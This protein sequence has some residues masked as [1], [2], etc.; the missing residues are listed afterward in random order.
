MLILPP[1]YFAYCTDNQPATPSASAHGTACTP[2]FDSADGTAVSL[3]T[4]I[5]HDVHNLAILVSDVTAIGAAQYTLMDIL[6]DPAGGSSWTSFIDDLVV[7]FVA[8]APQR[9]TY[10]FPIFIPAGS[11]IGVRMR[12]SHTTATASRVSI[13][14]SGEPSRPDAWWCGQGVETLGVTAGTSRGTSIAIGASS[15]WG[16][17]ASIGSPTTRRYGAIELG[18]NGSDSS[19]LSATTHMQVGFSSTVLP[20]FPLVMRAMATN[21]SGTNYKAGGPIWCDIA[22]GTQMQARVKSSGTAENYDIAL[23]GVY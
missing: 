18:D 19:A 16:A 9:V 5:A 1:F 4:A 15:A 11:S 22:S 6:V 17:W 2:G 3:I 10:N 20:G 12:T 8:A 21:E 23:Y 7:G 13:W 14:A